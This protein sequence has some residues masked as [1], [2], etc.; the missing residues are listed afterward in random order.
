MAHRDSSYICRRIDTALEFL[1]DD[2]DEL[3]PYVIHQILEILGG[4]KRISMD[5]C[6]TSELMSLLSVV[7]P[8]FARHL[9]GQGIPDTLDF[10]GGKV[11]RLI[12]GDGDDASTGT[13]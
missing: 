7:L 5:E 10:G 8:V 9:A 12:L 11:L 1:G 2:E 13:S 6:A 4:P 3:R